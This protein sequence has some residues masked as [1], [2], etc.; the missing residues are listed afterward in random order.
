MA[1]TTFVR[2]CLMLVIA[3]GGVLGVRL[4]LLGCPSRI[5]LMFAIT[6]AG[7]LDVLPAFPGT[8]DVRRLL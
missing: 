8:L 4:C 2:V 3:F 6:F 7:T 1:Y 5:H